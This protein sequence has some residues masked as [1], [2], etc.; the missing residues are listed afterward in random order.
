M[1]ETKK[2]YSITELFQEDA[3]YFIPMYQRNYSWGEPEIEQL[4]QDIEDGCKNNNGQNYYLG[5]LVV[6]QRRSSS[7]DSNIKFEIIDGQQRFTTLLLLLYYL[8]REHRDLLDMKICARLEFECR[9]KSTNTLKLIRDT[10][11]DLNNFYD[12]SA[13][14]TILDGYTEL[15]KHLDFVLDKE[16]KVDFVNYLL[17]QVKILRLVVPYGTDVNHYFEVMNNRGEQLEKH[18]VLKARLM[19]KIKDDKLTQYTISRIWEACMDMNRYLQMGFNVDERTKLFGGNWQNLQKKDFD[20]VSDGIRAS[21]EGNSQDL[22]ET[23]DVSLDDILGGKKAQDSDKN[24]DKQNDNTRFESIID[25]PNFLLHALR[26]Y[27]KNASKQPNELVALTDKNLL[28]SFK[29]VILEAEDVPKKVKE[30]VFHLLK[31]RYLFDRYIIKRENLND[32]E[33]WAIKKF[34]KRDEKNQSDYWV[35]FS[36]THSQDEEESYKNV[37]MLQTALHVSYSNKVYKYWLAAALDYLVDNVKV[38]ECGVIESKINANGFF[39]YLRSMTRAILANRLLAETSM[40]YEE[41]LLEDFTQKQFY[42]FDS[43]QIA[44]KLKYTYNPHLLIFN[45]LDF[46]L[47]KEK[48]PG[49]SDFRFVQRNSIEHLQPQNPKSLEGSDAWINKSIHEFGNLCLTSSSSNS[50]FRN[51]S[52]EEKAKHYANDKNLSLKHRIMFDLAKDGK[53]ADRVG[54]HQTEMILLLLKALN[55]SES[56]S[57]A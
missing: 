34:G 39:D 24:S 36:K 21:F 8:E 49:Y 23:K 9:E 48:R 38:N 2:F 57:I 18:E 3:S 43:K 42:K 14:L 45:Y 56:T 55:C 5:T 44:E 29:S 7:L 53:W 1:N 51:D 30:F 19:N 22:N 40:K 12:E 6:N 37:L 46:L 31:C 50:R 54:K 52:S 10:R 27:Q 4:I 15:K 11:A 26:S 47:W 33:D 20:G 16:D 13:T 25:F 41:V 32:N 28:E 17:E 35:T